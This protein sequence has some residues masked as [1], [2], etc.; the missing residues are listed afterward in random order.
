MAGFEI[1]KSEMLFAFKSFYVLKKILQRIILRK[2]WEP[3]NIIVVCSK[4]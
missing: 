4:P 3:N 1:L 2:R